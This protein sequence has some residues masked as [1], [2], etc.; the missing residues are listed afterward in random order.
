MQ[1]IRF[2]GN[3]RNVGQ[4]VPTAKAVEGTL[5]LY[6]QD[7]RL[8]GLTLGSVVDG[9]SPS[10]YT[11]T[12]KELNNDASWAYTS[13]TQNPFPSFT[14]EDS[15]TVPGTGLNFVRTVNG[16]TIDKYEFKW[17]E[18]GIIEATVDY[19]GQAVVYSSG[20]STAFQS[21]GTG[22]WPGNTMR[23]FAQKDVRVW[24]P[25]GTLLANVK[26]GTFT[27]QNG[28]NK[29]TFYSNG[30]DVA[31]APIPENRTYGLE[32]TKHADSA[33]SKTLYDQYF[34]GGS[35]FNVL[36]EVTDLGAGAG[37]RDCFI[38]LSGCLIKPMVT[39]SPKDGTDED[40]LTIQPTTC[41]VLVD[42]II[43]KYNAW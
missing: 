14:L 17:D 9:G 1:E 11:H 4:L 15:H 37:S 23:P 16:C 22:V 31:D 3:N 10:P 8:L 42:D 28:L 35:Q 38:T 21:S 39:T 24:L 12:I 34:K 36:L 25:S 40:T 27:I 33:W 2:N 26:N 29:D 20:A 32:I 6:P 30:S 18:K 41:S 19:V 7:W 43:F 5:T 13:G